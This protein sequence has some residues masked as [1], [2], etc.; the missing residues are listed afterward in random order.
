M[1]NAK[2]ANFRT[3]QRNSIARVRD[4]I[5]LEVNRAIERGEYKYV[6]TIDV[7]KD[8]TEGQVISTVLK[9][10]TALDYKVTVRW[11]EPKPDGNPWDYFDGLVEISWD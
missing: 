10:V 4:N 5:E 3:A 2:E 9:E 7:E 1:I 6:Y 8:S 11:A